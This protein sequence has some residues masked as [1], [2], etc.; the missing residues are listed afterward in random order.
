[1]TGTI[2]RESIITLPSDC[3]LVMTR[4]FNTTAPILFDVWTWKDSYQPPS[5]YWIFGCQGDS[6]CMAAVIFRI[7]EGKSNANNGEPEKEER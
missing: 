1:M 6:G 2:Q 7:P 4:S 3:E 5:E